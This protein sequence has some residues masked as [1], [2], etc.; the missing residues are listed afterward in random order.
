VFADIVYYANNVM[1]G[2]SVLVAAM[3]AD[4]ET[5]TFDGAGFSSSL[6]SPCY[7]VETVT[8]ELRNLQAD[9]SID[10]LVGISAD[11][12]AQKSY[13]FNPVFADVRRNPV[14]GAYVYIYRYDDAVGTEVQI[15]GSPFTTNANGQLSGGA[16][17]VL[18]T[19]E[20]NDFGLKNYSY[21]VRVFRLGF[22]ELDGR[23]KPTYKVV[24]T[25]PLRLYE[26]ALE[27][28]EATL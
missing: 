21:R 23:M 28:E 17:V 15:A 2:H 25:I 27:G 20:L 5:I 12:T 14:S 1:L 10:T 4:Y 22:Q 26:P 16:G 24:D 8:F 18:V 6:P 7:T 9:V 11:A 13:T 19:Q 3:I